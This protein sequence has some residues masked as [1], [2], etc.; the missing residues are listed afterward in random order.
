VN[1]VKFPQCTNVVW[2]DLVLTRYDQAG[3]IGL[4]L[5][6]TPSKTDLIDLIPR[7]R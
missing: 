6:Y 3:H 5:P 4:P 7:S 2:F 1:P